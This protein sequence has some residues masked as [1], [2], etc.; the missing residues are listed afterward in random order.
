M[1]GATD[2]ADL[3]RGVRSARAQRDAAERHFVA[4]VLA[5]REAGASYRAIAENAGLSHQ[6]IAQVVAEHSPDRS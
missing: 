2:V 3:L 6:R 5:A 1:S 4:I